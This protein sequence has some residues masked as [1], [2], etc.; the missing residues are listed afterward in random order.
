M[1]D[2]VVLVTGGGRGI[3]RSTTLALA[4]AGAD[5]GIVYRN[6][7]EAAT[8]VAEEVA[9]L[10]RRASVIEGNVGDALT[11]GRIVRET[12]AALGRLDA[13]VANAGQLVN[14]SFLE[15]SVEQYEQQ[16]RTNALGSFL[17]AQAAARQ[18]IVQGTGGRIVFVTSEAADK[19]TAGLAAYCVSKAAQKMVMKMAAVELAAYGIAANAVAPG[20][21]ETDLNRELLADPEMRARLLSDVV[22]GRPGRPEDVAGAVAFLLSAEADHVT[23]C[24]IA[25]NGG[26]LIQ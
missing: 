24:T 8:A 1:T 12:V 9:T 16:L 14:A 5:V 21:T 15:T 25:V 19:P 26:S 10:G 22:L 23:G 11:C 18:M 17:I 3:G 13:L 4:R 20:T 6:D 2:K 7:R